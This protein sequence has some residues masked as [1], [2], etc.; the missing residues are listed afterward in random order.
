MLST[1]LNLGNVE[2]SGF[3]DY[4]YAF[5]RRDFVQQRTLLNN[6]IYID[7]RSRNLEDGKEKDFWHLTTRTNKYFVKQG[8]KHVA[9]E[10]RLPDYA[11]SER[12]EWV[13]QII[14]NHAHARVKLFYHRESNQ[15]RDIRLYLWAFENDFVVILQKLGRSTSFLVTSFY[16]DQPDKRT[17]YEKRYRNYVAGANSVLTGCEW[18]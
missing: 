11:R 14:T 2:A 8:N 10:E 12:I 17:D 13:R 18:F 15:K 3:Y 5:F 9:V 7:P 6:S 16:I 1:P 4:L